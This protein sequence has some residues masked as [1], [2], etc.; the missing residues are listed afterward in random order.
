MSNQRQRALNIVQ[1][2]TTDRVFAPAD[3]ISDFFADDVFTM[4]KMR[5]MLAPDTFKKVESAIKKGKKIDLEAANEVASAVKTWAISKGSTHYTH[6]FQPLTGSTAE[7]HDSFFDAHKGL[8]VFK[9]SALIQQEPDASS[10]PNGGI[11]STFEA[12]GYTAWDPSSP[13][14]IWGR[15][16]CI[17]TVFVSYTGEALD[18]KAPLLKAVE[19]VDKTATKVCQLFDRNV[20]RVSAS[21][22]CEQEYFV[23]DRALYN[24]RPDLVMAGR[25]VFG[26]HPARGQQLDDHYFGSIPSRVYNYMKDFEIEC[27]KLGIPVMTRHNEVAPSQFEVAPIFEDI[28]VATDHNSLMMDVMERVAERHS[29]KVL[30]HEKPFAGLNG[31]GKH[32][33]WSLITLNGCQC[34]PA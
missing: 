22:G 26:H 16:L 29:L 34:I 31:S 24:A 23:I 30:F 3:K 27:L 8:E 33:N 9:G 28:N 6:W 19:A 15:T 1:N 11:R 18:Y 2:R 25:T 7:K 17:P 10:F 21:L 12:R 14:F 4:D 5:A 20:N 13:I 32:N